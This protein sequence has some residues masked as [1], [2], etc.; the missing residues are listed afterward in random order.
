M[1]KHEGQAACQE[2][3]GYDGTH[4]GQHSRLAGRH[5]RLLEKHHLGNGTGCR[6]GPQHGQEIIAEDHL[7][8]LLQ[9]DFFPGNL[10]HVHEP[11]TVQHQPHADGKDC[12]QHRPGLE[13]VQV[14]DGVYIHG[15]VY[16]CPGNHKDKHCQKE[17]PHTDFIHRLTP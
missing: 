6:P 3:D 1:E 5:P 7:H 15:K 9:G 17:N 11:G 13:H 12:Q 16:Y 2:Q 14:G 10:Y 8:R 4:H